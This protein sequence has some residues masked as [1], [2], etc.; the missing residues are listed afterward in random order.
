M[1]DRSRTIPSQAY[2]DPLDHIFT[3]F[4]TDNDGQ[5]SPREIA[6][7]LQSRGV[8]ASTEQVQTFIES[9]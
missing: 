9:E 7:A 2:T 6:R 8:K 4:D 1:W 5:L 3:E